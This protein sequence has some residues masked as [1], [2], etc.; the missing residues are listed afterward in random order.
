[1][2][3]QFPFQYTNEQIAE[4]QRIQQETRKRVD[5]M[6]RGQDMSGM[7]YFSSGG[8]GGSQHG[9]GGPQMM[10]PQNRI[11]SQMN[12][13]GMGGNLIGSQ[14]SM[15]TGM[16]INSLGGGQMIGGQPG[17]VGGQ[18]MGGQQ[19]MG[20]SNIMGSQQGMNSNQ[21]MVGQQG[22][23][24][25]QMIGGQQNMGG[26]QMMGTQSRMGGGQQSMGSNILL[27][28]QSGINPSNLMGNFNVDPFNPF[29]GMQTPPNY[30]PS[31]QI[32]QQQQQQTQPQQQQWQ[33]PRISPQNSNPYFQPS[34]NL[35][36]PFSIPQ[37]NG[38]NEQGRPFERQQ[39]NP[40]DPQS[41]PQQRSQQGSM[42][43]PF[44]SLLGSIPLDK[45][46]LFSDCVKA[47]RNKAMDTETFRHTIST[48]ISPEFMNRFAQALQSSKRNT[49]G[50][51][52]SSSMPQI[53]L[54]SN[55]THMPPLNR[56]VP[57]QQPPRTR[58]ADGPSQPQLY[59]EF[60]V[61][62]QP[63]IKRKPGDEEKPPSELASK[64]KA[65]MPKS[66]STASVSKSF[67]VPSVGA[68]STMEKNNVDSS[69]IQ[70]VIQYAGIDVKAEAELAMRFVERAQP[71]KEPNWEQ[72]ALMKEQSTVDMNREILLMNERL[73]KTVTKIINECGVKKC[74]NDCVQLIAVAL[75]F[76]IR[77]LLEALVF[78]S[79]A[80]VEILRESDWKLEAVDTPSVGLV[81][82]PLVWLEKYD[83][84]RE[85]RIAIEELG[86]SLTEAGK[87]ALLDHVPEDGTS[88]SQPTALSQIS[89]LK[90]REDLAIQARLV[91][92][93][94]LQA[95][96]LVSQNSRYSWMNEGSS[97]NSAQFAGA[98]IGGSSKGEMKSKKKES[99][100]GGFGLA[101][102][103]TRKKILE[104]RKSTLRD[105]L[106]VLEHDNSRGGWGILRKNKTI[107]EALN[108]FLRNESR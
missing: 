31:A 18:M 91:N 93:T 43:N 44:Q 38:D 81:K 21:M 32:L 56:P 19:G 50:V 107:L 92:K 74:E 78:S 71:Q 102:P 69:S 105:L 16:M 86:A 17:M 8:V 40:F 42:G 13:P 62:E 68:A 4:M 9:G 84:T 104:G 24:G 64:R 54:S 75:E 53:P 27:R 25:G 85:G 34:P 10:N 70:D 7:Q 12:Q 100:D 20:P 55:P 22:M 89:S 57:P 80:R 99:R 98:S 77:G 51:P 26:S 82:R 108:I 94:A 35:S 29:S 65:K 87:L 11:P 5:E 59:N 83:R 6:N 33:N 23:S 90:E 46:K 37:P 97:S 72:N 66:D 45:Q 60:S 79:K 36:Q 1:M 95:A 14:S 73:K 96:G 106:Y 52:L 48:H 47:L 15:N 30:Q 2:N 101:K 28:G 39:S 67:S 3:N 63:S 41:I 58:P 76:R 61:R 49:G 88:S 103:S